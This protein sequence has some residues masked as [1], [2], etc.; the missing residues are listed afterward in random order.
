MLVILLLSQQCDSVLAELKRL[1]SP[2]GAAAAGVGV[3]FEDF[4]ELS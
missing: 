3:P 2:S 4:M 1:N